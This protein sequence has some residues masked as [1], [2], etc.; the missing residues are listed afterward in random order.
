MLDNVAEWC[1][2]SYC[3]YSTEEQSDPREPAT[4]TF[5]VSR[6]GSWAD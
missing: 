6:G 5:P 1:W 2:D 3:D 4:G